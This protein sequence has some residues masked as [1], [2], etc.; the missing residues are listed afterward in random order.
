MRKLKRKLLILTFGEVQLK[1][2]KKKARTSI[3]R[4]GPLKLKTH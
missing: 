1:K 4:P 3:K 2:G